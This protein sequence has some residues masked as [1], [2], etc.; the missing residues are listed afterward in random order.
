MEE[1]SDSGRRAQRLEREERLKVLR[2]NEL[3]KDVAGIT[4][5]MTC[6]DLGCG[7][8]AF[9]FPMVLC[10]GNEGTVYAVDNDAE[11]IE[12]IRAKY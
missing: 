9:S 3:I 6:I 7:T 1:H 8:G 4:S 12:H 11:M 5:G 10:V 2:P